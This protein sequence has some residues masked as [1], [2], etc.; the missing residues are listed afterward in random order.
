MVMLQT[1]ADKSTFALT[2]L[3]K[4]KETQLKFCHGS[5]NDKYTT[6]QIK[7]CRKK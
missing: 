7:I 1:G 6:K 5:V 2:I 3:E 4:I